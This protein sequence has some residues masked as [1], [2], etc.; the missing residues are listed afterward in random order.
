MTAVFPD[1]VGS[2]ALGERLAPEEVKALIGECV[3]AMARTVE[4]HG[5]FVQAY[6]GDGIA[7]FFGIPTS[8]EDDPEWAARCALRI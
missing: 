4:D 3:S 5:G 1:V 7:A 8:H 2:T 6:M